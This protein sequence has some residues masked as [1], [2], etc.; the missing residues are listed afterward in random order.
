[1]IRGR[2]LSLARG[3]FF[4]LPRTIFH[5]EL[6]PSGFFLSPLVRE[7]EGAWRGAERPTFDPGLE[8][9]QWE[10]AREVKQLRGRVPMSATRQVNGFRPPRG[11][12]GTPT[13]NVAS[14]C[15]VGTSRRNVAPLARNVKE[16]NSE[17]LPAALGS[18]QGDSEKSDQNPTTGTRDE[19]RHSRTSCSWFP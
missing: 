15:R 5:A 18:R 14:E 13:R 9:D 7:R 12:L 6:R 2:A 4:F 1:M 19:K 10:A 16:G 17:R 8:A 11:R 3:F